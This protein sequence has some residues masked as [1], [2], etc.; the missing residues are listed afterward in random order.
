MLRE[1]IIWKASDH[2][3]ALLDRGEFV[4]LLQSHGHFAAEVLK[5]VLFKQPDDI[6]VLDPWGL[7]TLKKNKKGNHYLQ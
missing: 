3:K 6:G 7:G 5:G 2:A 1:I 4:T